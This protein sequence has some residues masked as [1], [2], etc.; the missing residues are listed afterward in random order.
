MAAYAILNLPAI[1]SALKKSNVVIDGLYSW[2]EYVTLKSI[3]ATNSI[4]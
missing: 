4:L 1:D 3:M 2:E